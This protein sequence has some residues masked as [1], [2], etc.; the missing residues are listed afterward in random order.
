MSK[1]LE[2]DLT[3]KPPDAAS[4][5]SLHQT[6]HYDIEIFG[7]LSPAAEAS[8][9]A[10]TS[11]C[12]PFLASSITTLSQSSAT[13]CPAVNL[14]RHKGHIVVDPHNEASIAYATSI[15]KLV[16]SFISKFLRM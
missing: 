6:N 4:K 3:H 9:S 2:I 12:D 11:S 15:I 14:K 13:P 8:T 10:S 1:S 16:S 5:R 7:P